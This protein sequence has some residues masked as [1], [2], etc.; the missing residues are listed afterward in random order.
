MAAFLLPRCGPTQLDLSLGN[1]ADT[2]IPLRRPE[3]RI[4]NNAPQLFF[5]RAVVQARRS[6]NIFFQHYQC[7]HHLAAN[8]LP[9]RLR[10]ILN[11]QLF[12]AGKGVIV[13]DKNR[14]ERKSVGGD[15]GVQV[16]Y[17]LA[18]AFQHGSKWAVRL[19][20]I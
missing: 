6:H 15:H 13:G 17:R 3:S 1:T 20:C 9:L 4:A 12:N 16:P 8:S 18:F 19:G 14:A 11:L 10:P 7:P 2:S 5:C